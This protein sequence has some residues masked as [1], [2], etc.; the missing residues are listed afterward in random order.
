MRVEMGKAIE[1]RQF[2]SIFSILVSFCGWFKYYIS[3][4]FFAG[5]VCSILGK[6]VFTLDMIDTTFM[7]VCLHYGL[8][9]KLCKICQNNLT[10]GKTVQNMSNKT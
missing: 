7:I 5:Y 10:N 4:T 8:M 6:V 2:F 3:I 1:L 9:V